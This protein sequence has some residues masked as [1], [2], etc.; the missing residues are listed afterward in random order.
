MEH[1]NFL[2]FKFKKKCVECTVSSEKEKSFRDHFAS[3]SYFVRL[4]KMRKFSLFSQISSICFA[5][6]N[7]NYAKKT[8][9][10]TKK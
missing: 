8:E 9:N 2:I 1:W 6:K 4:R 10:F 7:V 3:F 5:K